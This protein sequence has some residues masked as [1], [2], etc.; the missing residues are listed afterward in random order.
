ML[1]TILFLKVLLVLRSCQ[2]RVRNIFSSGLSDS[3]FTYQHCLSSSSYTRTYTQTH[4]Y[5]HAHVRTHIHKGALTDD[6]VLLYFLTPECLCPM[7]IV[8]LIDAVTWSVMGFQVIA[9]A[10]WK[11]QIFLEEKRRLSRARIKK[12]RKKNTHFW[13]AFLLLLKCKLLTKH[14]MWRENV[15]YRAVPSSLLGNSILYCFTF[16]TT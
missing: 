9:E 5:I 10:V 6:A 14:L 16:I 13:L 11:K 1:F 12:K 2:K 8:N 7:I 15:T 4:K 3:V